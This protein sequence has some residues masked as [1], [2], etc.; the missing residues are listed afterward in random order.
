MANKVPLSCTD[1]QTTCRGGPGLSQTRFLYLNYIGSSSIA[2]HGILNRIGSFGFDRCGRD[3]RD[4]IICI[5]AIQLIFSGVG[6]MRNL[7]DACTLKTNPS[8]ILR[9]KKLE[10][11]IMIEK[12]LYFLN[13]FKGCLAVWVVT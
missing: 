3:S 9:N 11:N 7:S 13:C 6:F 10:F 1:G 5:C 8:L 12:D 4:Y 2:V